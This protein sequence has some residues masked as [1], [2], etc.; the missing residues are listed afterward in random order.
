[1]IAEP[2][3]KSRI[4]TYDEVREIDGDVRRELHDGE[5]YEMLSPT[6][7]HQRIIT[8]LA[9][10]LNVWARR[11]G[12]G[13]A[14]V[15]PVD[16]YISERTYYIPDL[17]FYSGAQM[18]SAE[19]AGDLK[20]LRLAPLLVAEILSPSTARNDRTLKT[21][22]YADFGIVHYWIVDPVAQILEAFELRE[23][24]YFLAGTLAAE[25]SLSFAAFPD[26]EIRGAEL[27]P[28]AHAK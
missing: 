28:D 3:T 25:E 23:N 27:F 21:R 9:E 7:N 22:A 16:L 4:W 1:M 10:F 2:L 6:V 8:R 20:N 14:T 17:V 19:M 13:E 5:I 11:Q 24:R 12:G 15:S 26:L 18:Q